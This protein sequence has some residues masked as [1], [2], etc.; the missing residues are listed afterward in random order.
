MAGRPPKEGIEFSGWSVHVFDDPKIDRLIYSHGMDGF[1]VYFYLCQKAFALHGYYLPWGKED[2]PIIA[3]RIGGS[4]DV[5]TV[6]GTIETCVQV[7]LFDK[8]L[9]SEFGI[10]TSRG[11]QRS[12]VP[13]MAKRRNKVVISDYWLLPESESGGATPIPAGEYA[14][15]K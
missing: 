7:D 12:F 9:F 10:L 13:A 3:R 8:H 11:I 4:V 5:Q 1:V 15:R 2:A 14:S 6:N